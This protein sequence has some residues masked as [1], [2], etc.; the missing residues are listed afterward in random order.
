MHT[1]GVGGGRERKEKRNLES[2]ADRRKSFLLED[3]KASEEAFGP[4][5]KKGEKGGGAED[6]NDFALSSEKAGGEGRGLTWRLKA[7]GGSSE[8]PLPPRLSSFPPSRNA[9]CRMWEKNVL[10]FGDAR[11]EKGA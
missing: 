8:A 5:G 11:T 2:F 10:P 4:G 9:V 3:K 7:R 1:N 6:D